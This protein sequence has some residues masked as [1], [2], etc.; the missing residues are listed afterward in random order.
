MG[1]Y[2][3]SGI[4]A[5]FPEFHVTAGGLGATGRLGVTGRLVF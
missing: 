1:D 2:V 4:G 5:E 3:L